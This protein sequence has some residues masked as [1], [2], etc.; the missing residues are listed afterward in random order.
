M[1]AISPYTGSILGSLWL[2]DGVT[3]PAIVADGVLYILTDG[4]E[5]VAYR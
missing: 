5:L 1:V 4:A 3:I 2:S